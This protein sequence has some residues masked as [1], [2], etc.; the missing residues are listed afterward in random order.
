MT[1]MDIKKKIKSITTKIKVGNCCFSF[2]IWIHFR[3]NE[4][5]QL[6]INV[7]WVEACVHSSSNGA[8]RQCR[9]R[10]W[11]TAPPPLFLGHSF[12]GQTGETPLPLISLLVLSCKITGPR[13]LCVYICLPGTFASNASLWVAVQ[14]NENTLKCEWL[15]LWCGSK[16]CAHPHSKTRSIMSRDGRFQG[17]VIF[18]GINWENARRGICALG[19]NREPSCC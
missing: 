8:R 17:I 10:V 12:A 7:D 16:S 3:S 14:M 9:R 5:K 6:S 11:L 19:I 2:T 13:P 18:S 15:H 4:S 1:K